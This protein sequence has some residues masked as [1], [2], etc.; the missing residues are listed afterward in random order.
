MKKALKYKFT[1]NKNLKKLLLLTG[2]KL[3]IE[4]SPYDGFFGVGGR[5]NKPIKGVNNHLG[6]LLMDLRKKLKKK[7]CTICLKR[8]TNKK[9][10]KI[11][12]T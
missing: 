10:C 9:I 11:C 3:L 6:Y 2:D 1:Q 7:T 8:K 4:D 5:G 12:R